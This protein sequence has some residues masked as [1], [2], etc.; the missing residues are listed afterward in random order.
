MLDEI[1]KYDN[2]GTADYFFDA[3]QLLGSSD[4]S[5]TEKTLAHFFSNKVYKG[6]QYIDGG[7]YVLGR[8]G[9][10]ERHDKTIRLVLD[11]GEIP[12]SVPET[13]T[14]I[15]L[16]FLTTL[17]DKDE[18]LKLFDPQSITVDNTGGELIIS[19][20]SFPLRYRAIRRMLVDLGV[21]KRHGASF[22]YAVNPPFDQ[23]LREELS[24]VSS[25]QG[26]S[27]ERLKE[28]LLRQE[29]LG[30]EAEEFV[31]RYE[32]NRLSGHPQNNQIKRISEIDVSAGYDVVSFNDSKSQAPN[33]FIE[34]KSF[35]GKP[36][37]Y[38]TKNEIETAKAKGKK[39]YLY[40]VDRSKI[41]R[42]GYEP[43]IIK[44]PFDTVYSSEEWAKSP[45]VLYVSK[46]D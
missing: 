44:N 13:V 34:V 33:R 14:F 28:A 9:I 10:I 7:V 8:L 42:S 26:V 29:I 38:W 24:L 41:A 27:I 46:L 11:K 23:L 12:S 35:A 39:Y 6:Y 4:I 19:P 3:L 43:V 16:R 30:A 17:Q 5:W 36:G 40:L 18:L 15:G 20:Q 22:G 21:L 32:I 25:A 1:S 2:L 45:T 37:F 31:L